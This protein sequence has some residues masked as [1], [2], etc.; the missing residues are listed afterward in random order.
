MDVA[1]LSV[2][3]NVYS[4]ARIAEEFERAGHYVEHVD[5][6]KCSVQLGGDRPEIYI[7]TE[8]ICYVVSRV[9][10]RQALQRT[11]WSITNCSV[12]NTQVLSRV[13]ANGEVQGFLLS[14]TLLQKKIKMGV[15]TSY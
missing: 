1:I 4:T 8:N 7:G 15:V 13:R 2:S 11:R 9:V 6:T 3:L 5:H 12:Q 10:S 14:R